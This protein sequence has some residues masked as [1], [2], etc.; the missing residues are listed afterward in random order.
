MS[1]AA[2]RIAGAAA[3]LISPEG[4]MVVSDWSLQAS[5]AVTTNEASG[6]RLGVFGLI[7]GAR[8]RGGDRAGVVCRGCHHT[9]QPAPARATVEAAPASLDPARWNPAARL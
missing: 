1:P 8:R 6:S 3:S 5:A 4:C 7:G 9:T 2:R